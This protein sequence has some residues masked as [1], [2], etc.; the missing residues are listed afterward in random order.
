MPQSKIYSDKYV[1]NC[2]SEFHFYH[3]SHQDR[4]AKSYHIGFKKP[5][6]VYKMP[7]IHNI[8]VDRSIILV[9]S[10]F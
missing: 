7:F 10:K 9:I 1:P 2:S 5:F 6:F 4:L 8:L 3:F